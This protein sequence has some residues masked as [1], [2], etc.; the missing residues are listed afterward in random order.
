MSDAETK[1]GGAVMLRSLPGAGTEP[2]FLVP[3]R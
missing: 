2:A 1:V 3:G